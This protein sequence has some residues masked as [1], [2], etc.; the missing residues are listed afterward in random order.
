M[1]ILAHSFQLKP[2]LTFIRILPLSF[3]MHKTLVVLLHG[4]GDSLMAAPALH[5]LKQTLPHSSITVMTIRRSAFSDLWKHNPDV[6]EVISSSLDYNPRYGHP[7]FWMRDYWRIRKDIRAAV[8]EHHFNKVYFVKMYLMPAKIYSLL[9]LHR[10]REHKTFRIAREIGVTLDN[11]NYT[12]TTS[13]KDRAWARAFLKQHRLDPDILVGLHFRGSSKNK[14]LPQK[15]RLNLIQLLN[16]LGYQPLIFDNNDK[17][18]KEDQPLDATYY[19]SDNLLHTAALI[20]QCNFLVCIDSGVGHLA[21]ALNKKLFSIYFRK[22]WMENSQA[23]SDHAQPFYYHN[24]INNLLENVMSFA[25]AS[26][27]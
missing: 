19:L 22:I 7:L 21:A 20:D 23:L 2:P 15:T 4:I 27:L 3:T 13:N 17:I 1:I 10:Y 18:A 9:P 16:N 11:N 24:N 14:S 6:D 25:E 12:F 8:R 5:A 26:S